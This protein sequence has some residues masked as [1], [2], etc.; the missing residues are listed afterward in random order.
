MELSVNN[1]TSQIPTRPPTPSIAHSSE[2]ISDVP[3]SSPPP[4]PTLFNC[5]EI[6]AWYSEAD[7]RLAWAHMQNYVHANGTSTSQI[8]LPSLDPEVMDPRLQNRAEL[9]GDEKWP[10]AI[11]ISKMS[12]LR[13]LG[14]R[15]DE[16]LWKA[17][18][19]DSESDKLTATC[20]LLS[21]PSL[22]RLLCLHYFPKALL[23]L[24]ITEQ[25]HH[26][27]LSIPAHT[28]SLE[29][30]IRFPPECNETQLDQ[31]ALRANQ[32]LSQQPCE[33]VACPQETK[34]LLRYIRNLNIAAA[35]VIAR[36]CYH[37]HQ[38]VVGEG[39]P[40]FVIIPR[41]DNETWRIVLSSSDGRR[42]ASDLVVQFDPVTQQ[43]NFPESI[44]W[45]SLWSYFLKD[46][47]LL[48]LDQFENLHWWQQLQAYAEG[49]R[50]LSPGHRKHLVD[51][52]FD[53]LRFFDPRKVTGFYEEFRH[54]TGGLSRDLEVAVLLNLVTFLADRVEALPVNELPITSAVGDPPLAKAL[55]TALQKG[56]WSST[57]AA[58]LTIISHLAI[59]LSSREGAANFE[60]LY[61]EEE[62]QLRIRIDHHHY[63]WVPSNLSH[64]AFLLSRE[65]NERPGSLASIE[66]ALHTL[67]QHTISLGGFTF[68]RSNIVQGKMQELAGDL[69]IIRKLTQDLLN[70]KS[71]VL[72][73]L[74]CLLHFSY[75][76]GDLS[77]K[78]LPALPCL[79]EWFIKY[80]KLPHLLTH[81][82]FLLQSHSQWGLL[83]QNHQ[84]KLTGQNAQHW[85][86]QVL[87]GSTNTAIQQMAI[88]LWKETGAR[89][90]QGLQLFRQWIP[91]APHMAQQMH[92]AMLRQAI[93]GAEIIDA[94]VMQQLLPQV[95]DAVDVFH[96][97]AQRKDYR[98]IYNVLRALKPI[99]DTL[100][101]VLQA[102]IDT[103]QASGK[104][105]AGKVQK[106]IEEVYGT[107]TM[108][109]A[110]AKV[111][112]IWAQTKQIDAAADRLVTSLALR[113]VTQLPAEKQQFSEAFRPLATVSR[114][115]NELKQMLEKVNVL[116][117][118][119]IKRSL[120][121]TA[122]RLYLPKQPKPAQELLIYLLKLSPEK[123]LLEILQELLATYLKTSD[124]NAALI[125]IDG[126]EVK[127]FLQ[128]IPEA[129]KEIRLQILSTPTK[130]S[131]PQALPHLQ[132]LLQELA[133]AEPDPL[134]Q[135]D[136]LA[137]A[138]Q[139]HG[140]S[141]L[142][143]N[144]FKNIL[145]RILNEVSDHQLVPYLT[146]L[147]HHEASLTLPSK[148]AHRAFSIYLQQGKPQEAI[149]IY[150]CSTEKWT[151]TQEKFFKCANQLLDKGELEI[152]WCW[153]Q[154][155]P[156][157][158]SDEVINSLC[159][160]TYKKNNWSLFLT[161]IS[162]HIP[163]FS[164][165]EEILIELAQKH[166]SKDNILD[167]LNIITKAKIS[168]PDAWKALWCAAGPDHLPPLWEA[169]QTLKLD[170]SQ[171]TILCLSEA[172]RAIAATKEEA[173]LNSA[174]EYLDAEA[175]RRNSHPLKLS[176]IIAH[177][178][179]GKIHHVEIAS[180]KIANIHPEN[181]NPQD[182]S[183]IISTF[184]QKFSPQRR[185]ESVHTLCRPFLDAL[186]RQS[187]LLTDRVKL[188]QIAL[189]KKD[190]ENCHLASQL[191]LR[192]L[193]VFD[194]SKILQNE[195]KSFRDATSTVLQGL[196]ISEFPLTPSRE[197]EPTC[198]THPNLLLACHPQTLHNEFKARLTRDCIN[199]LAT[200]QPQIVEQSL[201]FY[202][203]ALK[204][205]IKT[206]STA[207]IE[208]LLANLLFVQAHYIAQPTLLEELEDLLYTAIPAAGKGLLNQQ[209]SIP[210][211]F[212]TILSHIGK[213]IACDWTDLTTRD[214]LLAKII[215]RFQT[216]SVMTS[217]QKK[218]M[219]KITPHRERIYR[220][221]IGLYAACR[222]AGGTLP[223]QAEPIIQF[224]GD[225][226]FSANEKDYKIRAQG[227]DLALL[228]VEVMRKKTVP[229]E[230]VEYY[231][232]SLR[233][234]LCYLC[235]L[236]TTA[237]ITHA[238]DLYGFNYPVLLGQKLDQADLVYYDLQL[239][240]Q[241]AF[242][243]FP[244]SWTG[245]T[246][247]PLKFIEATVETMKASNTYSTR[248]GEQMVQWV[249]KIMYKTAQDMARPELHWER[250]SPEILPIQEAWINAFTQLK[251]HLR[252]FFHLGYQQQFFTAEAMLQILQ[253]L[254]PFYRA[255]VKNHLNPEPIT[256]DI[257]QT[258]ELCP[259]SHPLNGQ[260]L[261]TW[262][263]Q[264]QELSQTQPSNIA[265]LI[266]TCIKQSHH[267]AAAAGWFAQP[268]TLQT[269]SNT[270]HAWLETNTE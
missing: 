190:E 117:S 170:Q 244:S 264:L 212:E 223:Q 66:E 104:G 38:I 1:V 101:W 184:Y 174:L 113:A 105:Y 268:D 114:S 16:T 71:P 62:T 201:R 143:N 226:L 63:V 90:E 209:E 130:K 46:C 213:I 47:S 211:N 218:F 166:S 158:I 13:V 151:I 86:I 65:L 96:H 79:M 144:V 167:I 195:L 40:Q 111:I 18:P 128:K 52:W 182:W 30:L 102:W 145:T 177:L 149:E 84:L 248:H 168:H 252:R 123:E 107:G 35:I 19:Q 203:K 200:N 222:A 31:T 176:L 134:P 112:S 187:L 153:M 247:I 188:A 61:A 51:L 204:K 225:H 109:H 95:I 245:S 270:L 193:E 72:H 21:G 14:K 93:S 147:S 249:Q 192:M 6:Q 136:T 231:S 185:L 140:A 220:I 87:S 124:L 243:P 99:C 23:Q 37:R 180:N 238:L 154:S 269:R 118:L 142:G 85:W 68:P 4:T 262:L 263:E 50:S 119:E 129:Y 53:R 121:T 155:Q 186:A 137:L 81:L 230:E 28:H 110:T 89:S 100:P 236:N 54:K 164:N 70:H 251:S 171:S 116:V 10:S 261:I 5:T 67:L 246:L 267:Q 17:P 148:I 163:T 138:I 194:P 133:A 77:L 11:R 98:G 91:I 135:S 97:L 9:R 106:L 92:Q 210:E 214:I 242:K 175:T 256:R 207:C 239:L 197:A 3:V 57:T 126:A 160:K 199:A 69:S 259:E 43:L 240:Y 76:A 234:L 206:P 241:F 217:S 12:L 191:M 250:A 36:H 56:V 26:K 2:R 73:A 7:Q 205:L 265:T 224:W 64:A 221:L 15:Q 127:T 156:C 27:F 161:V 139:V 34:N 45:N 152:C 42:L 75:P 172:A 215:N 33:S 132:S 59:N 83:D 22:E 178:E 254:L 219:E 125:L 202:C 235:E 232:C 266:N 41:Q 24:G 55:C 258:L 196:L 20:F 229:L 94:Q 216:W 162:Q 120:L 255:A 257:F 233:S 49:K 189:W 82:E 58:L 227:R 88:D 181:E 183:L 131:S 108:T 103:A 60:L 25:E 39:A 198:W 150:H 80:N 260:I 48:N 141:L 228:L 208:T 29:T 179:T 157:L 74:G 173:L 32:W 159:Q 146:F 44:T 8:P 237:S 253:E 169:F 165:L 122:I 78:I 115:P